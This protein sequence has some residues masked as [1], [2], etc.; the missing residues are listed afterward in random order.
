MEVNFVH[1]IHEHPVAVNRA[2]GTCAVIAYKPQGTNSVVALIAPDA[3]ALGKRDKKT[4]IS[5]SI[6]AAFDPFT[7]TIVFGPVRTAYRDIKG[8]HT[9]TLQGTTREIDMF[10]PQVKPSIGH[11]TVVWSANK[12]QVVDASS[13]KPAM[14]VGSVTELQ[15]ESLRRYVSTDNL[16]QGVCLAGMQLDGLITSS[17]PV[18]AT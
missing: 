6:A 8:A 1:N 18:P 3:V 13:G 14:E 7:T 10:P 16:A 9:K 5:I 15:K 4:G 11:E 17:A 2:L 12:D